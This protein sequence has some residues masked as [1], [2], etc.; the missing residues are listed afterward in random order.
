MDAAVRVQ[1]R[2]ANHA[3]IRVIHAGVRKFPQQA[4]HRFDLA[5]NVEIDNHIPGLDQSQD[6]VGGADQMAHLGQN[7][8][9]SM[10][11]SGQAADDRARPGVMLVARIKQPHQEAGV[12]DF[13]HACG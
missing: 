7:S 3:G 9:A 4:P 13:F 6:A 1:F 11:G 5:A 2:Q 12:S 10:E 8:L